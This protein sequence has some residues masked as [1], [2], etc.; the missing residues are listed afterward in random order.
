MS[1]R[2]SSWISFAALIVAS[3]AL[4]TAGF[5]VMY[6]R[7]VTPLH[8][9]TEE[10]GQTITRLAGLNNP[11]AQNSLDPRYADANGDLV[12]DAP[13]DPAKQLDPPTLTFCYVLADD[14][15]PFREAFAGLMDAMSKATGKPVTYVT[16]G[17]ATEKLRALRD[18]KLSVCGLSTGLVPL[19]VC[20]AG[21]V[22]IAEAAESSGTTAYSMKI[23]VPADSAMSQ[24]SD[25]RGHDL[26]L[27]EPN[28]N[29]GY[30]APLVLLREAGL[31]PPR[32]YE[33]RFSNSHEAS[34]AGIKSH[35]YEAA[36]V[37]GDVLAREEAAGHISPGDYRVIYTSDQPFPGAAIGCAYDLKPALRKQIRETLLNYDWKGTGL[38]K[39]LAAEGK[40][41]F[42]PI[43]Y[44]KDWAPVRRID[45]SIGYVYKLPPTPVV[46]GATTRQATMK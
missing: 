25:L 20:T 39:L 19:G 9:A 36:A 17:G 10:Q 2:P 21:F 33:I 4:V 7:Q 45:D 42:V 32:D 34:I 3:V 35:Q 22:P 43:D 23:I 40:V 41:K 46:A 38:E 14:D 8:S 13:A 16:Y 28:S 6:R 12:A 1:S 31:I 26:T 37:A 24:L 30:K 44:K 5:A 11:A 15:K 18:G 29:S 27:T